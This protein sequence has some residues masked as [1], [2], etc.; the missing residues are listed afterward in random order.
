MAQL[1]ID[2]TEK[3]FTKQE[4]LIDVPFLEKGGILSADLV[5]I[6][7]NSI[8]KCYHQLSFLVRRN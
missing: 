5:S 7:N 2:A 6:D 4:L 1:A 8:I 3:R